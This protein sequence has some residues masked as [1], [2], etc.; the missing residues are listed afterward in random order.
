MSPWLLVIPIG[1]AVVYMI[2][3]GMAPAK[4]AVTTK[5][6]PPPGPTVTQSGG[7]RA[8]RYLQRLDASLFAFRQA[9]MIG[10]PAVTTAAAELRGT[11]DVVRSMAEADLAAE[12]ITK[13][14]MD[15]INSKIEQIK[16]EI[17]A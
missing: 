3:K 16:K 14:D 8:L 12:R 10:G 5:Y 13:Q 1:G 11:L 4:E 7:V 15:T 6:A 2:L 17:G 9:R